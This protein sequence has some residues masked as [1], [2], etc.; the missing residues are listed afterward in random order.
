MTFGKSRVPSTVA[1]GER[2]ALRVM[3]K[4]GTR[5]WGSSEVLSVGVFGLF[6]GPHVSAT[7]GLLLPL[8]LTNQQ[9]TPAPAKP[10][11]KGQRVLTFAGQRVSSQQLN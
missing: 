3:N 2:V 9:A 11:L 8:L 7:W 10:V 4:A 6:Q 1:R 5:D